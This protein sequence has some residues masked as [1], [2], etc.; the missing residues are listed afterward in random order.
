[1]S[2]KYKNLTTSL[3][4]GSITVKN[5]FCLAPMQLGPLMGPFGEFSDVGISYYE[6]RAKGGFGLLFT[7]AMRTDME[8]DPFPPVEG[9]AP[10]R[11]PETFRRTAYEMLDRLNAYDCKMIPQITMGL[12]RNMDGSSA[13]SEIPYFAAPDRSTPALTT[14]QVKKKIQS[15]VQTANFLKSCGF[16]GIEVHAMHWGYLLDQ[17]AMALMNHRTDEYGGD[18]EGRMHAA[19]EI[20]QGIKQVCGQDFVVTMRLG[21][22]S[23]IKGF[24][25]SS[26]F[27]EEEAGR[28]L[29]EGVLISKLLESYGYDALSVDVGVYDSYYHAAP[30]AYMPKGHIIELAAAA[31]AKVSIPVLCGSRMNDVDLC[32]KAI[33][34]GKIDG[35]VLGRPALADPYY[36]RK[37][38]MGCPEKIR[39]CIA[40]NQGCIGAL[41][42]GR[43]ATCAVNPA[44]G[45]ELTFGIFKA[46]K[47]KNIVVVGGGV[48]GMEAARTAAL[49]GHKVSIYEKS[50]SLG[51]NVIPGG[52]HS[53]KKEMR[54]LNEW[55]QN[56]LKDLGIEEH[57]NTECTVQQILDSKP[58]A[59]V[60][61]VGSVPVMP[62]LPGINSAKVCSSIDV[63]LGKKKIGKNVV[64]AGGGLVGCE[65]ACEYAKE[66]KNVTLIEALSA[67]LSAGEPIPI[68]NSMMLND[69]LAHYNVKIMTGHKLASVDEE[70]VTVTGAEGDTKISADSVVMAVGYKSRTSMAPKLMEAGIEVYEVGDGKKVGNVCTSIADAYT[71]ARSI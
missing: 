3:K 51:G 38:E 28:T 4:I 16:P 66:G 34:E 39:P 21:L 25:Q 15:M 24:N 40:C 47:A 1:M 27:G 43:A 30:P 20:C 36:P 2:Q 17:F 63:L 57:M 70:G 10:L 33:A 46:L 53:F 54:E 65:I 14:D 12:G 11:A 41:M 68:M 6:E 61:A 9:K 26:L 7:G 49:R 29:E 48:A 42:Q 62:S 69:L 22:K 31:R 8:V 13:P 67:I 58:D 35:V 18:L 55:Y 56:E 5:R 64:V 23:Y 45:R 37:T 52:Q 19:R 71:V 32:E 50:G 60:L 59:V 44:A